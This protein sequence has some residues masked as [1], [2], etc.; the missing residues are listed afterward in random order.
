MCFIENP[1]KIMKNAFYFILEG[2]F[3]LKTFKFSSRLFGHVEKTAGLK[4]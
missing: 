1:L 3:V 4:I 2:L